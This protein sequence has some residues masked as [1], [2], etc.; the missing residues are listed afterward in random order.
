MLT[1]PARE[2]IQSDSASVGTLRQVLQFSVEHPVMV[3]LVAIP[4]LL[5]VG[6]L[7]FLAIRDGKEVRIWGIRIRLRGK[8]KADK[9]EEAANQGDQSTIDRQPVA[10]PRSKQGSIHRAD[11]TPDAIPIDLGSIDFETTKMLWSQAARF[12]DAIRNRTPYRLLELDEWYEVTED[13]RMRTRTRMLVQAD[14][15]PLFALGFRFGSASTPISGFGAINLRVVGGGKPCIWLPTTDSLTRKNFVVFLN[16]PLLPGGNS[17]E[18]IWDAEWPNGAA[19]LKSIGLVDSN[20]VTVPRAV[21]GGV[22]V[23]R[24]TIELPNN[25]H[26][27]RVELDDRSAEDVPDLSGASTF[28]ATIGPLT[29]GYEV[30]YTIRRLT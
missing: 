24:I 21:V 15:Q 17:Y 10:L 6:T 22:A 29:S 2:M 13:Y 11:P 26:R 1:T 3:T 27:Y 23:C 30:H 5:T 28:R 19:N 7:L 9:G 16:P 8:D 12:F 14:A 25:G 18:L 4:V 20:D